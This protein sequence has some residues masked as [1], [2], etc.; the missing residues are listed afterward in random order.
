MLDP[1]DQVA[2]NINP[3]VARDSGFSSL[4]QSIGEFIVNLLD[5]EGGAHKG[6]AIQDHVGRTDEWLRERIRNS[7][8]DR[9]GFLIQRDTRAG[10]FSSVEAANKLVNSILSRNLQVVSEVAAGRIE[11]A[12]LK[13]IFGS[14]TGREA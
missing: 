14:H 3:K 13:A 12:A 8:D 10:T 7:Y 1:T 6:H 5:E 2:L 11:R 9:L 4:I